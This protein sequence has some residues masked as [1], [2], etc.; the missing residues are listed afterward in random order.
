MKERI[1]IPKSVCYFLFPFGIGIFR[2]VSLHHNM[3]KSSRVKKEPVISALLKQ[4]LVRSRDVRF[5]PLEGGVS[6]DIFLVSDGENR[7]VV[8]QALPRLR[9]DDEW[10]ADT[11]RNETEQEFNRYLRNILPDAVPEIRYRDREQHFFVMEYLDES[12]TCWKDQLMNGTFET[13]TAEHAARVLGILH[14]KS[15]H[16]ESARSTFQTT[17]AF[18]S[19]RIEPYLLTTGARHPTLKPLFV[20]EAERLERHRETLVHGDFSPKNILVKPGR[21]VLLDHEVAWFGDPAFDVAFL[22]NHLYLKM[23]VNRYRL[24]RLPDLAKAVWERYF[25]VRGSREQEQMETRTGRLLLMLMLARIDGKSPVGY[26][27]DPEQ[28]FVRKFVHRLLPGRIFE[29]ER[30]HAEWKL[31]LNTHTF[32]D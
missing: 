14:H 17:Q 6:S 3:G 16:D 15:R 11:S 10:F 21:V 32:E 27:S 8:K 29:Q 7:V 28:E 18:K 12:F 22:L 19:L 4:G 24:D 26:L 5:E 30:I 1:D 20:A 2:C 31:Q 9:V 13:A 25:E 23:L